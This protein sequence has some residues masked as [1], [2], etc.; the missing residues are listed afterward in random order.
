MGLYGLLHGQL[1]IL[2]MRRNV[3]GFY[4]CDR[5]AKRKVQGLD[6]NCRVL[7]MVYSTRDY[8]GFGLCPSSG[9]PEDIKNKR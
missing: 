3:F 4:S 7:A 8:C 9:N 2:V 5:P 6:L 1:Y